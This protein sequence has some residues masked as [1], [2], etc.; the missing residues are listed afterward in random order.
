MRRVV[1]VQTLELL[2]LALIAGAVGMCGGYLMAA[3]LL[4][5]VAATLRGLYGADVSGSLHL[6]PVWWLSGFAIALLG[7]GLAAAAGLWQVLRMPLLAAARSRAWGLASR[8]AARWQAGVGGA[9][10][11]RLF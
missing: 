6:R 7:T 8:R 5:D 2:C 1:V 4:P 9:L 3:A 11:G 10:L